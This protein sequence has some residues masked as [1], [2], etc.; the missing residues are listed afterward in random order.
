MTRGFV[1]LTTG[2]I[3]YYKM[4]ANM[5][6]SFRLHNPEKKF[7]II[8]DRENEYTALFDNVVVLEKSNGD[9]RDKFSL[10]VNTPYDESIF[11]EPDCLIY[12]NLEH[13]WDLLSKESDCSSFGWND[14][15]L[16]C[17]FKTEETKNRVLELVPEL[18]NINNVP[19]FNPGYIFIRK[20][21]GCEKMYADCISI[22]QRIS[23][24]S[25]LNN[26]SHI[27]CNGKLRDDPV[28]NMAMAIN[29]F[30]CNE[31]PSVAKCIA[32][33]STK[34]IN[35]IDIINGE[36]DTT[37]K[38]GKKHVSCALLHFSTRRALEEGLYLWQTVIVE[39]A[40]KKSSFAKILNHKCFLVLFSTYR[41]IKTSIKKIKKR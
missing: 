2:D 21:P 14:G 19:L 4:A 28:F 26:Y 25:L 18:Q 33:P 36:L 11:I 20:G 17:W 10:L 6:A 41:Y 22:A 32:L 3:K 1:T 35:N 39:C 5:L 31:K 34:K 38:N 15:G 24:D 29:D 40:N 37:D 27:M 9:Y 8:C 30:V 12:H 13:F 16:D 23:G 7:A